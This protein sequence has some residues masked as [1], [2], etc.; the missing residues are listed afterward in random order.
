MTKIQL[1]STTSVTA[2]AVSTIAW[3]ENLNSIIGLIGTIVS[4]IFGIIS[5]TI[6]IYSR[7]KDKANED[8]DHDGVA[9]GLTMW[10]IIESIKEGKEGAKPY[11]ESIKHAIEEYERKED[12]E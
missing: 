10:N 7:L 8:K 2:S 5:L 1:S 4:A 12:Q 3:V 11:I 6:L 9:D